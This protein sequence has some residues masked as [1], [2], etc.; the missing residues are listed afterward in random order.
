MPTADDLVE[1]IAKTEDLIG[2]LHDGPKYK[3]YLANELGVSKSTVYNWATDL[4]EYDIVRRTNEG[5]EL[6]S[7]GE[8]LFEFYGYVHRVTTQFYSMKPLLE[9][10]P[11]DHYPPFS[12]LVDAEIV[13]GSAH[14]YA[15][16]ETLVDWIKDANHVIG[17]PAII[18]TEKLEALAP[19]FRSNEMTADVVLEQTDVELMER[20]VP[21]TLDAILENATVYETDRTIPIRLYVARDLSPS[22]GIVTLSNNRQVSMFV[23]LR[24]DQAVE[25]GLELYEQ[26][27]EHGT[28]IETRP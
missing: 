8:Q 18:S 2:M 10:L 12:A 24:G 3:P 4:I 11:D 26:Y 7:L 1:T 5:Y 14:P 22:V 16:F 15:P 21:D 17:T 23:Q 19:K 28:R 27:R 13:D 6:T 25:W 20:H 9:A